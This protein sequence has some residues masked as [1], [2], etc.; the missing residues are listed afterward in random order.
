YQSR[1]V[2]LCQGRK[3]LRVRRAFPQGGT[4]EI[5][6]GRQ[7]ATGGYAQGSGSNYCCPFK[8][9]ATTRSSHA[10]GNPAVARESRAATSGFR[11]FCLPSNR[12]SY[13]GDEATS[14]VSF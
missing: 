10:A 11:P 3:R 8:N 2:C 7:A 6:G 9:T 5:T 12:W 1:V 4:S 14:E 13:G